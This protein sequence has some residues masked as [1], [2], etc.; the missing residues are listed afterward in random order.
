MPKVPGIYNGGTPPPIQWDPLNPPLQNGCTGMV[1][2][3]T[4]DC[5]GSCEKTPLTELMVQMMN[6]YREWG[7]LGLDPQKVIGRDTRKMGNQIQTLI[8]T[9]KTMGITQEQLD[10]E[11]M[12]CTINELQTIR[13][14]H[15]D[16]FKR[17]RLGLH[18]KGPSVLGPDGRPIG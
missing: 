6:E 17:M 8:N 3:H 13:L 5:D 16:E 18:P 15:E 1:E 10:D 12:R 2:L 7:K 9:L 11:F 14:Q 4:P